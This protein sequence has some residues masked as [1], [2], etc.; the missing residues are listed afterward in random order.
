[1]ILPVLIENGGSPYQIFNVILKLFSTF[2]LG[3]TQNIR[4]NHNAPC[5]PLVLINFYNFRVSFVNKAVSKRDIFT[6]LR[7]QISTD[8]LQISTGFSFPIVN[9]LRDS[10]P[11]EVLYD[12]PV[13][14]LKFILFVFIKDPCNFINQS[15]YIY[16]YIYIYLQR[17]RCENLWIPSANNIH[18]FFYLF[19]VPVRGPVWPRGFQEV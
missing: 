15:I 18:I 7:V 6:C 1:M 14:F 8:I 12:V 9:M 5:C 10:K 13:S 4:A 19:W 17:L 3:Q 16:I 2:R 11:S